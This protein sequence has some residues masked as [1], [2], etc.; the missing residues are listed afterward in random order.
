MINIHA[1]RNFFNNLFFYLLF[2]GIGANVLTSCKEEVESISEL[3]LEQTKIQIKEGETV[4][5]K[6]IG[7]IGNNQIYLSDE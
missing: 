5:R 7:G 1:M 2:L 6:I 3:S 4:D